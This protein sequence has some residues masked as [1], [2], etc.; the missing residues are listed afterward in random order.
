M[1]F[2]LGQRVNGSVRIVDVLKRDVQSS[3]KAG[4]LPREHSFLKVEG[5]AVVTSIQHTGD[6]MLVRLFNPY[7][8]TEKVT[9]GTAVS[10]AGAKCVTLDGRDEAKSTILSHGETTELLIPPKRIA[11]VLYEK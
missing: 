11:T 4:T 9:I 8:T 10:T 6:D 2:L 5:N 1:L 7:G 3:N